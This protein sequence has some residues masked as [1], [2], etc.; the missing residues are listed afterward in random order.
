M[1]PSFY[2]LHLCVYVRVTMSI[3][4]GPWG[5]GEVPG[6]ETERETELT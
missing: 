4:K 2:F 5:A 1:D 3:G 6:R